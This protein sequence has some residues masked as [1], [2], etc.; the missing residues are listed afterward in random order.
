MQRWRQYSQLF[1]ALRLYAETGLSFS[2]QFDRTDYTSGIATAEDGEILSIQWDNS[3][4]L[5][6]MPELYELKAAVG[7]ERGRWGFH[8][9][10]SITTR[11]RNF[12]SPLDMFHHPE[13]TDWPSMQADLRDNGVGEITSKSRSED[14]YYWVNSIFQ[15]RYQL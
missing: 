3:V 8:L 10:G 15:I 5:A 6:E 14:W 1:N 4:R 13:M 2:K 11:N 9:E 12:M 7:V